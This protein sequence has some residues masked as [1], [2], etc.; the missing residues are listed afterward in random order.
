MLE[1]RLEADANFKL[2][3]EKKNQK[4]HDAG[5]LVDVWAVNEPEDGLRMIDTGVDQITTNILE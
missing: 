2:M 3:S 4:L 1:F 5:R